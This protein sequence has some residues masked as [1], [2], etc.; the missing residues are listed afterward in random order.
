MILAARKAYLVLGE[1]KFGKL[2]P[3]ENSEL[4]TC[5]RELRRC[6]A[7]ASVAEA[8]GQKGPRLTIAD[9]V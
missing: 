3:L 6:A 1:S 7:M 4:R 5:C 9:E 2:S 8:L